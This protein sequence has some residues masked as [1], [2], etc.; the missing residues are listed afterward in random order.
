MGGSVIARS[1]P[2]RRGNHGEPEPPS[3]ISQQRLEIQP[4]DSHADAAI[5]QGQQLK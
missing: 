4:L 2:E 3:G 1:R 5:Q